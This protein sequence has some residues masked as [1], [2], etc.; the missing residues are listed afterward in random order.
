M[1]EKEVMLGNQGGVD[2]F[3]ILSTG[4]WIFR[5]LPFS[6]FVFPVLNFPLHVIPFLGVLQL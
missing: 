5:R 3:G 2:D 1:H 4:E 6:K